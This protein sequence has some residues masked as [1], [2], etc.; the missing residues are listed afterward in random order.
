MPG[1]AQRPRSRTPASRRTE[2]G[3]GERD[4]LTVLKL[5]SFHEQIH[6]YI[7]AGGELTT[8]HSFSLAGRRF[9][10][11]R[12]EIERITPPRR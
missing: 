7:S 11:L 3:D 2:R 6:V 9:L 8:D 1:Y 4:A 10:T 5:P 12:Y